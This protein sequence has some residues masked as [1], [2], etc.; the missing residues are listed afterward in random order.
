LKEIAQGTWEGMPRADVA[1]Q[2]PE[3]LAGWRRD[4]TRVVAPGGERLADVAVRV[5]A[6]LSSVLD[7]LRAA[8]SGV[9]ATNLASPVSGYPGATAPD[10]P[11]S[12][13]VGHDGMFKVLLLTLLDM[14]LDRF[15]SFPFAVAGVTIVEL[16][17]GRPILRLHAST[18][19]LA[20]LLDERAQSETDARERLGAL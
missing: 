1:S 12:I 20:P 13:V 6:A 11:W 9:T 16:R 14:P 19:H 17:A 10:T 2:Y 18:E 7:A 15:W 8:S 5:G 4:P 3:E